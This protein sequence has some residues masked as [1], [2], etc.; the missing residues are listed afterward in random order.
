MK[1]VVVGVL[2]ESVESAPP[3]RCAVTVGLEN[4]GVG[5]DELKFEAPT[6]VTE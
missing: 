5:N 2:I 4:D 6:K 3:V 1:V